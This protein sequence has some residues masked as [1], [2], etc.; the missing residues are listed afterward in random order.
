M[1]CCSTYIFAQNAKVID[2]PSGSVISNIGG[3]DIPYSTS[4]LDIRSS[5]KGVLF[6]RVSSDLASPTEGL[7]YY[8]TTGH[9]FRYYDGTAWQNAL[10]GN[11]WNV[12]GNKISYS[13][14]NVGIGNTNPLYNLDINGTLHTEGYGYIDGF[15]SV[16]GNSVFPS[17]KLQVNDGSV[18]IHNTG[19]AKTWTFNYATGVGL[20]VLEDGVNARMTFDNG[21]NIGIG[22]SSPAYKLDVVGAIR[23]SSNIQTQGNLSVSGDA[24]VNGGGVAYNPTNTANLKIYPFTTA[25]FGADLLAHGS[26]VT[27][28][29]FGGGFTSTPR[30]FVGDIDYTAGP[31]GELE[32]VILILR[33][34][35][36]SS[37]TGNTTCIAKIVNTDNAP[38]EY[39][40][41]WNMLA[42]GY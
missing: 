14:G 38:L 13:L 21:G 33:G 41:R 4:I 40:I 9:N 29:V 42:V 6:P 25:T 2:S 39:D 31:S 36:Y 34:C 7:L 35:S 30:V 12:N 22:T 16:G 32:R 11:Q 15:L 1:L 24:T 28:I 19:D 18:A 23:A 26:A 20:R 17:Y 5:T 3:T 27:S 8:N 10:F 37:G